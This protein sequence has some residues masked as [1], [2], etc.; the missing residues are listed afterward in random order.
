MENFKADKGDIEVLAKWDYRPYTYIP[1]HIY[2]EKKILE[3]IQ[4]FNID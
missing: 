4:Y 1:S 2:F 3:P